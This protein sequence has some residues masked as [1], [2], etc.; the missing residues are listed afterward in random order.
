MKKI[1][2][3]L[4]LMGSF[5]SVP[6]FALSVN[7]NTASVNQLIKV[8]GIGKVKAQAIIDYCQAENKPCKKAKDLLSVKGIG[9]KTL[10]KIKTSIVFK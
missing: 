6:A 3:L 5:A 10:A 8:Q 7:V 9:D 4:F 2:V 1:L